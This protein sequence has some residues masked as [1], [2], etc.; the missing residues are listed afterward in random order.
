M[1]NLK[2]NAGKLIRVVFIAATVVMGSSFAHA[3][4]A[5]GTIEPLKLGVVNFKQ[6]VE[7]SKM[8]KQEAASFEALKTQAEQV[9][10]NKEKDLTALA[11]KLEDADYVDSLSNEAEAELKHKFRALNQ[12]MSQQQQQLYQTLSQ[13]NFKIV[14][15]LTESV[16]T[17]AKEV[18]E[19][20]NLNLVINEDA[21]FYYHG[22]L[23]ITDKVINALDE[24]FDKQ[25][26]V[27]LAK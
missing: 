3:H 1:R 15:K 22:A 18:G 2:N 4:A 23:D 27:P 12:E 19:K 21:C 24:G 8:G 7:K 9:L 26:A 10:K 20:L 16:A 6:C 13:A 5:D 25:T 14:Q 11:Q 17:T